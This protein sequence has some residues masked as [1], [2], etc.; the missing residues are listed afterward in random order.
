MKARFSTALQVGFIAALIAAVAGMAVTARDNLLRQNIATGFAFLR[1][2]T[3]WDVGASFLSQSAAD[4][5]WWTFLVGL[6]NTLVLSFVCIVA[7]TALGLAFA[8]VGSG[9]SRIPHALTRA[10]VWV[11]RNIPLIVQVFFWYH[12]TRSLPPVRQAIEFF[13]CC[14]ASNRG[15][16]VPHVGV[17]GTAFDAWLVLIAGVAAAVI[18]ASIRRKQI[19]TGKATFGW[20]AITAA[21]A[22]AALLMGAIRLRIDVTTPHLQGFNFV[23]GTYLS[24][25][26]AALVIAIVAYNIAFVAE[27]VNSG[28]RAVPRSQLEAARIIGL[29][30]ARIFWKITVPQAIRVAV[31]PLVN[32]YISITKSSSLAIV[33]GYTDL[34]SVGAIAINHTGQSLDVI[35]VLM[36][37]Y[38]AIS[39]AISAVGNAY[40]R[41]ITNRGIR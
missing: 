40:N 3:G 32:Q 2:R 21:A 28:I 10:Y 35:A 25:E 12:V 27:I 15:I 20:I 26:F 39:T 36:L 11:F 14:F 16:Y 41:A 33:I 24:P 19:A 23:E 18:M 8:L 6:V 5:Y 31:P 9:R 22:G 37:V 17:S 38:L 4:P 1:D 29:S 30:D 13:G 34:F 7:A